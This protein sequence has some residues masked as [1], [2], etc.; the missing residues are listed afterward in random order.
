[1][2]EHY[3]AT[4]NY[5]LPFPLETA[6][7]DISGDFERLA[8]GVDNALGLNWDTATDEQKAAV[9]SAT[10]PVRLF[11][12]G[13]PDDA[14][15]NIQAPIGST[16]TCTDPDGGSNFGARVWRKNVN[17][18]RCVD[19]YVAFDTQSLIDTWSDLDSSIYTP[20]S[21]PLGHSAYRRGTQMYLRTPF[22]VKSTPETKHVLNLPLAMSPRGQWAGSL[23]ANLNV[24]QGVKGHV[25]TNSHQVYLY[26]ESVVTSANQWAVI[27]GDVSSRA[28][29]AT[30]DELKFRAT[31]RVVDDLRELIESEADPEK[32]QQ[33]RDELDEALERDNG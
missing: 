33:L 7:P 6:E 13:R 9:G 24:P 32:L 29:P 18:W 3:D 4:D 31:V 25:G 22:G 23:G 5:G 10:A 12:S 17:E 26:A 2:P 11:G 19:G 16:F 20:Y 1:M 27:S 28:W 8:L 21:D 14:G 30:T 15:L